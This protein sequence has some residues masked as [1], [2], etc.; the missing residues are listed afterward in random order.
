M[1]ISDEKNKKAK[2]LKKW[3]IYIAV[4]VIVLGG[5]AFAWWQFSPDTDVEEEEEVA[6]VQTTYVQF[7]NL[8]DSASGSGELVAEQE[9][10]LNFTSNGILGELYVTAGDE[11]KEGDALAKLASQESLEATVA[12]RELAYVQAEQALQDFLDNV[13][14]S[15]AEAYGEIITAKYEYEE[16]QVD[17]ESMSYARCSEE[18]NTRYAA[19]V[20]RFQDQL[21]EL[22][23]RYYGSDQWIEVKNQLDTALANLTYCT[24]YSETELLQAQANMNIAETAYLLAQANYD[25]LLENEGVD[26]DE[27]ELLEAQLANAEKQLEV[28]QEDLEGATITAPMD[29]TV[30]SVSAGVG[31]MV[32]SSGSGAAALILLADQS[33]L[34]VEVYIDV[35]DAAYMEIGNKVEVVF[36]AL[37]DDMFYGELIQVDPQ[38]YTSGNYS[39]LKGSASLQ[40]TEEDRQK[41]MPLGLSAAVDVISA[42]VQNVLLVPVESLKDLGD[43][44]YAVF[45]MDSQTG[46]LRLTPVEVGVMNETY[47]EIING[48]SQGDVVSTGIVDTGE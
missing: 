2:K 12:S 17:Y 14:V 28:A 46:K 23:V 26:Q 15:L 42:D 9:I 8:R 25:A 47:A 48:L 44:T 10:D 11:V 22:S 32:K 13:G 3:T 40:L 33:S 43:E 35:T 16:A 24:E 1:N 30:M 4:V 6:E 5:A 39:V 18:V 21:D 20:D 37:P 29:G 31:E 34:Y 7:G 38:I 36:D 19:E 41:F 45:V 27:L